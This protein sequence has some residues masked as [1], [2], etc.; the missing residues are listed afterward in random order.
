MPPTRTEKSRKSI[1][2]EGRIL[3]AIQAIRKQEIPSI[4]EAARR[5]T[6]PESTLRTRLH[7]TTYRANTRA[8]SYKLTIS[9]EES[10]LK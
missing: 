2:Q 5:F 3:L 10:L 4:R 6:V 1:E 8:N 9:K 7:G